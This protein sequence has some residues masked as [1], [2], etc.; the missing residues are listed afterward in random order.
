MIFSPN[1][2]E[3]DENPD[4]PDPPPESWGS[5]VTVP[6][7][8]LLE[9]PCPRACDIAYGMF[10][11]VAEAEHVVQEALL[12]VHA[13]LEKGEQ[14]E[15]PI[16]CAATVTSPGR[17]V[18]RQPGQAPA[19][20]PTGR[21]AGARG[22]AR[23]HDF[24]RGDGSMSLYTIALFLHV[25][26][27]LGMFGAL[28]IEWAAAGPLQRATDVA[29]ARPLIR[30]LRSMRRVAGPSAVT[31][32]VTGIYMVATTSA[33]RQPWIGL[34]LLG[35]VLLALLGGG[36]TG[37]RMA[38]IAR[39]VDAA[40]TKGDSPRFRLEDPVLVVSL[41]LRTAVATGVVFL[42]TT[43]PAAGLALAVMGAAVAFGLAWSGP[44]LGRRRSAG[45]EVAP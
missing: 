21:R 32:L 5:G 8:Q 19:H 15:S 18:R 26:G 9:E 16:A 45:V 40:S 29:Q 27:A 12:R 43:K 20:R 17:D 28:G 6:R 34:G 10:G 42:M 2:T 38:A 31:L 25:M 37:R 3:P 44:V 30:V 33:G 39:D 4:H 1:F 24:N 36:V 35:L 13:A 41:R 14:I 23:F 7:E 22:A 11:S